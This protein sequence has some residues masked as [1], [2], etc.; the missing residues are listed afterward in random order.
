MASGQLRAKETPHNQQT[1]KLKKCLFGRRHFWVS[2]NTEFLWQQRADPPYKDVSSP[3]APILPQVISLHLLSTGWLLEDEIGP[4]PQ[5]YDGFQR[6]GSGSKH[7]PFLICCLSPALC[8]FEASIS[9][10][11]GRRII[12]TAGIHRVVRMWIKWKGQVERMFNPVP[13]IGYVF[14]NYQQASL[15]PLSPFPLSYYFQTFV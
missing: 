14:N 3:T 10:P 6:R 5:V 11:K 4:E 13:P 12:Q 9:R 7:C 15:L 8:F 2:C 1:Q